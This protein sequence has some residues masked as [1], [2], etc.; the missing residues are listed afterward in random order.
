MNSGP[1]AYG[2]CQTGCN[3]LVVVNIKMIRHVM[4]QQDSHLEQ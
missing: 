2:V 4:Q 1:I 3:T